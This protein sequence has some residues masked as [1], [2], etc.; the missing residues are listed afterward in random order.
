MTSKRLAILG[1]SGHGKVVAEIAE[2]M[3][4]DVDFF[5]DAFDQKTTLEHW[6]VLGSSESLLTQ[7]ECYDGV[8]IAI[9]NN[10]IRA[11]KLQ[12]LDRQ[13][14]PLPVLIH[15]N[16]IVS[17]YCHLG[18]GSVVMAGAIINPF[19]HVGKG[20]IVNTGATIDHD[21]VLE[22]YSHIS[23]NASLAGECTLGAK[24]WLGI[25]CSVKQQINIG[26]EAVVGAG[27]VVVKDI[28]AGVVAFGN[29]A[30]MK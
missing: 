19:T 17:K 16:A 28:P 23:P 12:S 3:G 24:A 4:Y 14:V 2:L 13:N 9:G 27:S 7:L 5:D 25:G 20:V 22:N 29:P 8:A 6:S 10:T 18:D 15:P 30:S 11:N 21:C 26:A 1:A